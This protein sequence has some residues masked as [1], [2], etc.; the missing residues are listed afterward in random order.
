MDASCVVLFEVLRLCGHDGG[1]RGDLGCLE[2]EWLARSVLTSA[3]PGGMGGQMHGLA[4]GDFVF[5]GVAAVI[6]WGL[7]WRYGG[8]GHEVRVRG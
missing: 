2:R 8:G 3:C 6:D 1:G 7:T 5:G 4:G